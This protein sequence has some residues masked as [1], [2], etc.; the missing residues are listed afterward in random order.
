MVLIL[1]SFVNFN[2]KEQKKTKR[3]G[4]TFQSDILVCL[5]GFKSARYIFFKVIFNMKT[6]TNLVG[7]LQWH[8]YVLDEWNAWFKFC[9]AYLNVYHAKFFTLECSLQ[10]IFFAYQVQSTIKGKAQKDLIC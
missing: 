9:R 8:Q 1:C 10:L 4:N 6:E 2:K 5:Q 3:P 7:C